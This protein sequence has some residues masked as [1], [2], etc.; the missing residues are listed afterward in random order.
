MSRNPIPPRVPPS[1]PPAGQ[2]PAPTAAAQAPRAPAP[3]AA[4]TAPK[5]TGEETP[6]GGEIVARA[7]TYYRMTR[8][9]MFVLLLAAAAWFAYDGWKGWPAENGRHDRNAKALEEARKAGD[10][11][12][13]DELN[14]DPVT[15]TKPHSDSDILLQKRLAIGLP[16]VAIGFL[17]WALYNSRGAYRLAGV[18]LSVPGHPPVQLSEIEEIHREKWD[19]KGIAYLKY[20]T[21]SGRQG[22]LRLDDFIY[23]REPTDK[24]FERVEKFVA[25]EA[26]A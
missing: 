2:R 16:I 8:Y 12:R 20:A 6:D 25:G 11:K 22:R 9:T 4:Y 7:A 26:G 19:R 14:K 18:T 15:N 13:M 5:T 23:E 21:A 17:I 3:A 1:V 24:I 10:E